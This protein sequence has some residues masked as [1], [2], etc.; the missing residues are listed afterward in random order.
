MIALKLINLGKCFD[1]PNKSRGPIQNFLSNLR[2]NNSVKFWAL[3]N[4]H[5]NIEKGKCVGIIGENGAGKSTLLKII[6][7]ITIPS[8][9]RIELNGKAGSFLE[10]GVGFLKELNGRENIFLYGSLLGLKKEYIKKNYEYIVNFSG[11]REVINQPVRTYSSGML[12][13]LAFSVLS[14]T[15]SDIM[16]LDEVMSVGDHLF[17]QKSLSKIQEF[18]R[19]G[20]TIIIASHSLQELSTLCDKCILLEE[21][22]ISLFGDTPSVIDTYVTKMNQKNKLR[23]INQIKKEKAKNPNS[24]ELSHYYNELDTTL[25]NMI[26]LDKEKINPRDYNANTIKELINQCE[27][28]VRVLEETLHY[29]QTECESK[30]LKGFDLLIFYE[31]LIDAL[32]NIREIYEEFYN[33]NDSDK[34]A[35]KIEIYKRQIKLFKE[36][37]QKK[38]SQLNNEHQIIKFY[39]LLV[40]TGFR[41]S[42]SVN[43][44]EKKVILSD[45]KQII[46]KCLEKD[47]PLKNVGLLLTKVTEALTAEKRHERQTS[48]LKQ[49]Q[50]L[51]RW[52]KQGLITT[53]DIANWM[54]TIITFEELKKKIEVKKTVDIANLMDKIITSEELKKKAGRTRKGVSYLKN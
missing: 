41:F 18:K 43:K 54:N 27:E 32:D 1:V 30:D 17:R 45:I 33:K 11:L 46:E 36:A 15:N 37:L 25:E 22:R 14:F 26:K 51:Q 20:M 9:G 50:Q 40:D 49:M 10:L 12:A 34:Q 39:N 24:I 52:Q 4:I 47:K 42:D 5:L 31:K 3:R 53:V 2:P 29:Y 13:R 44:N 48:H 19:K 16:L 21:G 6:A 35:K 7:G 38:N 28:R 8:E 23:L